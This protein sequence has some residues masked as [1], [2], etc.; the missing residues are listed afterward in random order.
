MDKMHHKDVLKIVC[1]TSS[2]MSLKDILKR[3]LKTSFLNV[4]QPKLDA[5]FKM[6][7]YCLQ[8]VFIAVL[9]TSIVDCPSRR[10]WRLKNVNRPVVLMSYFKWP[11]DQFSKSV[12]D[13]A[14]R[15]FQNWYSSLSQ[16]Y[17]SRIFRTSVY[18]LNTFCNTSS[19]TSC[20]G[21]SNTGLQDVDEDFK[22]YRLDV[23]K[24][25]F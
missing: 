4:L 23:L 22:T 3:G 13:Q 7:K 19:Y 6:V 11:Q 25:Y 16:Q 20:R 17:H 5:P 2:Q 21:V 24:T 14:W 9:K 1:N 18:R 15:H 12:E 8:H 10:V